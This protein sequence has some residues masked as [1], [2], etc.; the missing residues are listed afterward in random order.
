MPEDVAEC[1][2]MKEIS[3]R[4]YRIDHRL[5]QERASQLLGISRAHLAGIESGHAPI[6]INLAR[7]I[8]RLTKQKA[9]EI[10]S[11]WE[12]VFGAKMLV[13]TRRAK[14]KWPATGGTWVKIKPGFEAVA[15]ADIAAYRE[16]LHAH[17]DG[18]PD[19]ETWYRKQLRTKRAAKRKRAKAT[20]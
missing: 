19:F 1:P 12:R 8:R 7:K 14:P 5:T 4:A 9:E 3:I 20:K 11:E 16:Q 15:P 18:T 2:L 10:V 17:P 13:K 6:T